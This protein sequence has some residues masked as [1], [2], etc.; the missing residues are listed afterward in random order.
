M[1]TKESRRLTAAILV[2]ALSSVACAS[3]RGVTPGEMA[4]QGEAKSI[5]DAQPRAGDP[6]A[7]GAARSS[8]ARGEVQG[9][10]VAAGGPEHTS[11]R[12]PAHAA[13]P[14]PSVVGDDTGDQDGIGGTP[15][16]DIVR[17]EVADRGDVFR[18]TLDFAGALP[19]RVRDQENLIAGLG[20]TAPDGATLAVM[21][22]GTR[23]GWTAAMQHGNSASEVNSWQIDG[24]RVTWF[25]DRAHVDALG[26]SFT[27]GASLKLLEF[28]NDEVQQTGDKAPESGPK[29]YSNT[30]GGRG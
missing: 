15:Y 7:K 13:L 20:L 1:R 3:A 12:A 25:V 16:S 8:A 19:D 24:A 6:R 17:A 27:W 21:I 23:D 9:D 4:S 22:Q 28:G 29:T 5:P 26:S 2:A 11:P 18:F 30:R 10:A 14:A